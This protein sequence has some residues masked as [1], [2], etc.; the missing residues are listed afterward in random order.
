MDFMIEV[1]EGFHYSVDM[2]MGAIFTVMLW[3]ILAPIEAYGDDDCVME[4]RE[5][6]KLS[7]TTSQDAMMYAIPS[8]G[9]YLVLII[10]PQSIANY[11]VILYFVAVVVYILRHGIDHYVQH[12]LFC[13]LYI[14][15]GIFL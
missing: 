4:K 6:E 5:F 8:V 13:M 14:A 11:C 2:W 3:R 7:Q 15:F 10:L 9:A 12:I 1:Y